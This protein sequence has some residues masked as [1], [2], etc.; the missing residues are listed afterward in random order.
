MTGS[1]GRRNCLVMGMTRP[2]RSREASRVLMIGPGSE[3]TL[4]AK[5][6]TI[7]KRM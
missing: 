7:A 1:A 2:M 6:P 5:M 4:R 3:I